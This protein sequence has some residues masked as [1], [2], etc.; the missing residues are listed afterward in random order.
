MVEFEGPDGNPVTFTSSG[1]IG[2]GLG[3]S[4]GDRVTLINDPDDPTNAEIASVFTV[5]R[6]LP[7]GFLVGGVLCLYRATKSRELSA[8]ANPGYFR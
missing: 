8:L 2:W 6:F 1:S 4:R 5:L 7:I 3:F